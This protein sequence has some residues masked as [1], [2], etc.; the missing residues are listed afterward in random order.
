MEQIAPTM[1][2]C[3]IYQE[4]QAAA[5]NAI[6]MEPGIIAHAKQPTS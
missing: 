6:K 4:K 1:N 3:V 5:R 2:M